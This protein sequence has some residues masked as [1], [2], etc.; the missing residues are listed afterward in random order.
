MSCCVRDGGAT[1]SAGRGTRATLSVLCRC[2]DAATPQLGAERLQPRCAS[3]GVGMVAELVL[4]DHLV[5]EP[6][7]ARVN[8]ET[9]AE[10]GNER[11][12]LAEAFNLSAR[13]VLVSGPAA[14]PGPAPD[15]EARRLPRAQRLGS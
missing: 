7:G 2:G 3:R 14:A 6:G 12:R 15:R 5:H 8:A 4:G 9:P 11:S 1:G 13:S 10:Q